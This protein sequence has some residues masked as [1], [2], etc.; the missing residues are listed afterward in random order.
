M[1][2][3]GIESATSWLIVRHA[4]HLVSEA[5]NIIIINVPRVRWAGNVK[6]MDENEL[7]RRIMGFKREGVRSKGGPMLRRIDWVGEYL[8]RHR[9]KGW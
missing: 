1:K 2:V 6:C 5:P 7:A 3:P 4:D 8:R 9:I